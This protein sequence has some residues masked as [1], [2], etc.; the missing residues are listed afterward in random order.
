MSDL[1]ERRKT[2]FLLWRPAATHPAPALK[3]GVFVPG[4]PPSLQN[5][6][7]HPLT[8]SA[9]DPELW[10]VAAATLGLVDSQ[11]YHYWFRL[12]DSFVYRDRNQVI[13]V[14]DPFATTVDWRVQS[15]AL[16]PPYSGDDR[17]PAGVVLLQNQTLLPCDDFG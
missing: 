9:V 6:R 3:I 13:D 15:D 10:E 1:L 7:E 8:P 14:T 11:V 2:H 17:D 12:Q 16:P 4:N 5:V